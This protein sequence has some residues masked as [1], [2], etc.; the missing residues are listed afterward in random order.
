MDGANLNAQIGLAQ[1]GKYGADVMHMNLHKTFAIP[2]GGGGPGGT[3]S[4]F[5]TFS[6]LLAFSS[7]K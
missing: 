3:N 7:Y 4:C 5:E 6:R 1:P 2:H